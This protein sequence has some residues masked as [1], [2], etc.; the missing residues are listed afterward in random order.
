MVRTLPRP[1][2]LSAVDPKRIAANAVV[3]ALHA[4]V[5]ALLMMPARWEPPAPAK[6]TTVVV[7]P[8]TRPEL[9]PPPP[10]PPP[11]PET[12][13]VRQ[14]PVQ[15]DPPIV[16]RHELPPIDTA[17]VFET[18]EIAAPPVSD[19]GPPVATFEGPQLAQ[20]AYATN[21]APRYPRRSIQAGHEGQV[22]LRVLVGADGVPIEVTIE[23]GSGHRELDRAAREQVLAKWK[24]HPARHAGGPVPAYALVP[25][26]FTLP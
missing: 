25:I 20:L 1:S 8:E 22:L 11:P 18:G 14:T 4:F 17:P 9:P 7:L 5:F 21:P 10:P 16:V 2:P 26:D 24:F 15:Q 6:D 3:L 13:R 19:A 23:R 12:I